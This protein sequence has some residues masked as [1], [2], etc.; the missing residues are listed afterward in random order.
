MITRAGLRSPI[1]G[2]PPMANP[3][4]SW[5]SRAVARRMSGALVT[6]A[7]AEIDPVVAGDEAQD[8]VQAGRAR[9]HEQE[10]LHDLAE[11]GADG[12][13]RLDRGVGRLIEGHDIERHALACGG[14]EDALDRGMDGGVGHG[15]ESSIGPARSM[16]RWSP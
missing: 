9:D 1:G 4:R 11:L 14:I 2:T 12:R 8:G 13:G 6:A 16:A 3:V 5:T 15:P 7:S 10:R